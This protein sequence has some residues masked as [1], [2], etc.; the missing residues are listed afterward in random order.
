MTQNYDRVNSGALFKNDRREKETH[1]QYNGTINVAGVDY[2]INA[3]VKEG[4]SGKFFSLSVKPKEA[5]GGGGG[6]RGG[7][8]QRSR[9][10]P[11][12]KPNDSLEDDFADDDIPF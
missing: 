9:P 5:Q 3:W 12:T 2:W 4:K 6:A 1:P 7:A 11:A 10:A 8:P